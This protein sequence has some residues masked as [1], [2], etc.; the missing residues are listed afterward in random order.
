MRHH[1]ITRMD[2]E[3]QSGH[4]SEQVLARRLIVIVVCLYVPPTV[5]TNLSTWKR[6]KIH[7]SPLS[8]HSMRWL[9]IAKCVR[10]S[11][12]QRRLPERQLSARLYHKFQ[13]RT[14]MHTKR[15]KDHNKCN[16]WCWDWINIVRM[17]V[18]RRLGVGSMWWEVS[19][20][21]EWGEQT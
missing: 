19:N 14:H 9:H 21:S 2:A 12:C 13:R 5:W 8:S 1:V 3:R 6:A 16:F 10:V 15:K 17:F 11:L 20:R 7:M 4:G 18:C